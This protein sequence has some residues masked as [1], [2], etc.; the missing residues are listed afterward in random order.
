MTGGFSA[1]IAFDPGRNLGVAAL[2][3]SAGV[4]RSPSA[5]VR[6]SPPAGVRRSPL[7]GAVFETLRR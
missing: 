5:G 3:D 6:R 2:A 4:R 7:E 1:M